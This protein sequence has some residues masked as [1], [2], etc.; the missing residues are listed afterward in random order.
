MTAQATI[1]VKMT[2]D[3]ERAIQAAT[4]KAALS[5]AEDQHKKAEAEEDRL[6]REVDRLK[7]RVAEV[8]GPLPTQDRIRLAFAALRKKGWVAHMSDQSHKWQDD[9]VPK[10]GLDEFWNGGEPWSDDPNGRLYGHPVEACIWFSG[11]PAQGE[12]AVSVLEYFGCIAFVNSG[13]HSIG[14]VPRRLRCDLCHGTGYF[15]PKQ[16]A[17]QPHKPRQDCQKCE[18]NC[19]V[20]NP[21]YKAASP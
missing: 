7:E 6:R 16:E 15:Y 8:A 4:L 20:A 21:A 18:G 19:T 17:G 5:V 10:V 11:T 9:K 13:G 3:T 14:V 2:Y 12:E 1:E